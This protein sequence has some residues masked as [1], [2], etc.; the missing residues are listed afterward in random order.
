MELKGSGYDI[1]DAAVIDL[2]S[3]CQ[4]LVRLRL[5]VRISEDVKGQLSQ[6]RPGL[7][8]EDFT[9]NIKFVA[10][11]GTEVFFRCKMTTPLGKLM[12]AYCQRQGVHLHQLRF[13]FDGQRLRETQTPDDL[14]MEDGDAIDAFGES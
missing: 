13:L 8:I 4:H 1:S 7:V 14:E 9:L 3:W 11:D 2:V 12:R 6:I 10:D 5:G